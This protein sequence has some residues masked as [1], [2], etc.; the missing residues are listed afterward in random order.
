M[1]IDRGWRSSSPLDFTATNTFGDIE[2]GCDETLP[3][4]P[5]GACTSTCM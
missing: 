3:R 5:S 1:G 2:G 4:L